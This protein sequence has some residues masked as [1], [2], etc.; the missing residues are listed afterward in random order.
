MAVAARLSRCSALGLV[1]GGKAPI[2]HIADGGSGCAT[3]ATGPPLPLPGVDIEAAVKPSARA[4][5]GT[6]AVAASGHRL[7][8]AASCSPLV[9][10]PAKR[11]DMNRQI[12]VF[13]HRFRP[14]GVHD[15][16][17]RDQIA[18]MC[19]EGIEHRERP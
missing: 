3:A 8:A 14:D 1:P 16:V 18:L 12:V 19:H 6:K 7:D 4:S 17:L 15:L 5:G 10:N 11:R 9:E 2:G 13:D